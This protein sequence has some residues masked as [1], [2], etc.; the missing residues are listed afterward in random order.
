MYVHKFPTGGK[1]KAIKTK[2]KKQLRKIM[3]ETEVKR[4]GLY[5]IYIIKTI[6]WKSLCTK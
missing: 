1:L 6:L 3:L 2:V 4:K 5:K